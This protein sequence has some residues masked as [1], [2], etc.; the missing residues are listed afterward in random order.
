MER[1]LLIQDVKQWELKWC[2]N[3]WMQNK[4]VPKHTLFESILMHIQTLN[5]KENIYELEDH[6]G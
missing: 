4:M 6:V 1:S 3:M 2:Q 5:Y